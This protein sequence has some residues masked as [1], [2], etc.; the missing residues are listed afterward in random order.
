MTKLET[1]KQVCE[2]GLRAQTLAKDLH[3]R[4]EERK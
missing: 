3:V 2:A 4:N 1:E